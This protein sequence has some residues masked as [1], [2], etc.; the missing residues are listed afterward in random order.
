MLVKVEVIERGKYN[1]LSSKAI[2]MEYKLREKDMGS[3]PADYW[4][5][6]EKNSRR[7]ASDF[8]KNSRFLLPS[9]VNFDVLFPTYHPVHEITLVLSCAYDRLAR[10]RNVV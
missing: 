5:F 8:A 1:S 6:V 7:R 9:E 2:K 10:A 4:S 3:V